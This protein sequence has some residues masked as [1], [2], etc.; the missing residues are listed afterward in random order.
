MNREI[1]WGKYHKLRSSDGYRAFWK[2]FLVVVGCEAVD[3]PAFFQYVSHQIFKQC[4]LEHFPLVDTP[5]TDVIP[6]LTCQPYGLKL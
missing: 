1:I 6:S 4:L 5:Q 3:D 2:A